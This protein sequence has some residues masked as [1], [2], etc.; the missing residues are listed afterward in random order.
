MA[1][2][3]A[4]KQTDHLAHQDL[5]CS[6]SC[7]QAR[8]FNHRRS[9]PVAILEAGITGADRFDYDDLTAGNIRLRARD[10]VA[11]SMLIDAPA[12]AGHGVLT[13]LAAEVRSR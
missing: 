1:A 9:E 8:T 4:R 11:L 7:A 12:W 10:F 6:R 13:A 2:A 5:A 3:G